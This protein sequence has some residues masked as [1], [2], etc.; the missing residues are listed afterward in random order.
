MNKDFRIS[1]MLPTHPKVVKLMRL[2]GDRCFYNLIRL[3][4]FVAANKPKGDLADMDIDDI[5]IASDWQGEAGKFVAALVQFSFL[6]R[7][8]NSLFVHDWAEHNAYAYHAPERNKRAKKA[9]AVKH[10][11]K[12][13][14]AK[15]DIEH[16]GKPDLAVLKVQNGYAPS[17]SPS[18]SPSPNTDKAASTDAPG[19]ESVLDRNPALL[20]ELLRRRILENDEHAKVPVTFT[21]KSGWYVAARLLLDRDKRDFAEARR[22]IDWAASNPFW[23]SNILSMPTF[24][25]K[26]TQLLLRMKGDGE[27][28]EKQRKK[29]SARQPPDW[30]PEKV[31]NVNPEKVQAALKAAKANIGRID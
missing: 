31:E 9:A 26:Y 25:E 14:S 30:K 21:A 8:K 3:W 4:A 7:D 18:P 17:P 1:V 24:R 12:R 22:L 13:A 15:S 16:S 23:K 5:E 28:V 2:L 11:D 10:R 19:G 29:E 20:C 27:E 6:E